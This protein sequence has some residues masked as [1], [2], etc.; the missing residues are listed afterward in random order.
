M[1]RRLLCTLVL[2]P[3]GQSAPDMALGLVFLQHRLYLRVERAVVQRQ[4]LGQVLM[5][6]GFAD[7]ELFRGGADGGPVFYEVKG[8]LLGP[9]FQILS[10]RA[11]LPYCLPVSSWLISMPPMQALCLSGDAQSRTSLEVCGFVL[12][13]RRETGWQRIIRPRPRCRCSERSGRSG[14]SSPAGRAAPGGTAPS[15]S[16]RRWRTACSRHRPARSTEGAVRH[17]PGRR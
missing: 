5:Y 9:L 16:P 14:N 11:P 15:G 8:Q 6:R 3:R 2:L 7:A 1:E 10:D 17:G 12:Y 4:A 13:L